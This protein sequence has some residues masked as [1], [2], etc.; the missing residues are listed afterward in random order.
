MQPGQLNKRITLLKRSLVDT[1]TTK[2]GVFTPS[3][4]IW[5]AI[6]WV[7]DGERIRANS[8][9]RQTVIRAT[10]RNTKA[11]DI[12]AV[13][14]MSYSG[15]VYAIEGIK[16]IDNDKFLE[17]TLGLISKTTARAIPK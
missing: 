11:L 3:H 5:A 2:E 17:I 8:V 16:P 6:H 9:Q 14:R 1:G 4:T 13:D 15:V 7:S 10:I 12:N